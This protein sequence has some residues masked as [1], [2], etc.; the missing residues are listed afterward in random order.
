MPTIQTYID[1]QIDVN[2][3]DL[4]FI[5]KVASD[6]KMVQSN[7]IEVGAATEAQ[8]NF[9]CTGLS[10]TSFQGDATPTLDTINDKIT[11]SAGR[12]YNLLLSNGYVF[13]IAEGSGVIS[14][15]REDE[16]SIITWSNHAGWTTQDTY[17]A[18]I[19]QG[20]SSTGDGVL[21]PFKITGEY[22]NPS[23]NGHNGAETKLTMEVFREDLGDSEFHYNQT[24][25]ASEIREFS[26]IETSTAM[27]ITNPM[28][29][30]KI[31]IETFL[32]AKTLWTEETVKNKG[33]R[34]ADSPKHLNK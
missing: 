30:Q 31:D 23:I 2:G 6:V 22:T 27:V 19:T 14:Y 13:D 7:C 8:F 34:L 17:H 15:R 26:D 4:T 9:D 18:N 1:Q 3:D 5:G 21:K 10:V 33:W 12:F 32:P 29:N 11:F 25:L 28:P 16:L 20:F 24:T